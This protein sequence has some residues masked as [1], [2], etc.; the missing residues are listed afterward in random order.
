[1]GQA[2][3]RAGRLNPDSVLAL[4]PHWYPHAAA[5][6]WS[7]V[8]Q[9]RDHSAW[10]WENW[11]PVDRGGWDGTGSVI[12]GVVSYI[13]LEDLPCCARSSR[14]FD[15][16]S[17]MTF[18]PDPDPDRRK[19]PRTTEDTSQPKSAWLS[20]DWT[21]TDVPGRTVPPLWNKR[22]R[23]RASP[24]TPGQWRNHAE[25]DESRERLPALSACHTPERCPGAF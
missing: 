5:Q 15:F 25:N 9:P 17:P 21:A 11:T 23:D 3:V 19:R 12:S 2:A 13:C 10:F 20:E 14:S 7:A 22:L 24:G 1:M 4:D 6:R 8:D 18:D 16:A